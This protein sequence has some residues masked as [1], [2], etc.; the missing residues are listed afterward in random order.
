M[1]CP[2]DSG[3]IKKAPQDFSK[4][5]VGLQVKVT[6]GHGANWKA[7]PFEACDVVSFLPTQCRQLG[8]VT[9]EALLA[10]GIDAYASGSETKGPNSTS[11]DSSLPRSALVEASISTRTRHRFNLHRSELV[12]T[13]E[14]TPER[15]VNIASSVTVG[16]VQQAAKDRYRFEHIFYAIR[17]RSK[18][19]GMERA[20]HWI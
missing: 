13:Q 16:E 3:L 7:C 15:Q 10:L 20:Q 8:L 1:C 9:A 4:G 18:P 12:P 14:K 6:E 2:P 5:T 17:G 11:I 19:L